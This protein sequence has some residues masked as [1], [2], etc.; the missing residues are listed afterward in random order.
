LI[1]DDDDDNEVDNNS[2]DN[3]GRRRPNSTGTETAASRQ[4]LTLEPSSKSLPE[5]KPQSTNSDVSV[6]K[7][8]EPSTIITIRPPVNNSVQAVNSSSSSVDVEKMM[9]KRETISK[10]LSHKKVCAIVFLLMFC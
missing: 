9:V 6:K 3:I 7:V 5:S 4:K 1:S 8:S 2:D 10:L